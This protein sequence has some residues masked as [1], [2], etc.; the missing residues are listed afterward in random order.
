MRGKQAVGGHGNGQAGI[1]HHERVEHADAADDAA[2]D[3]GQREQRAAER[4]A[5]RSAHEPVE[6]PCG[7][8]PAKA[9]AASGRM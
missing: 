4:A 3:D 7:E 6:K 9:M 2:G 8:S 5:P 1:A